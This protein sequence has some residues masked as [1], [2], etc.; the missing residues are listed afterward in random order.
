VGGLAFTT[1]WISVLWVMALIGP[2]HDYAYF[3]GGALVTVA[4]GA[5]VG[6]WWMLLAPLAATAACLFAAYLLDPSCSGCGEDTWATIPF[7]TFI[8]FTLPATGA[9]ALGV[10]GRRT[11]RMWSA[12]R[13]GRGPG[14]QPRGSRG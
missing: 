5:S 3:V 11:A 6:S 12:R 4:L 14:R 8:F 13:C 7:F 1:V 2:D 10:L 9:V